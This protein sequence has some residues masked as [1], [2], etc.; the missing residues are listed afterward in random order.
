MSLYDFHS[1]VNK[2]NLSK[3]W[4]ERACK[5]FPG[6]ISHNIRFFPPYPFFVERAHGKNLQ[7]VDGNTFVDFWMGHWA[8]ILGHSPQN[9]VQPLEKALGQGTIFGTV[10]D[11][12]VLLGEIIQK[13]V[14]SAE[15]DEILFNW[16]RSN[17]VRYK[18][19]SRIYR[20]KNCCQST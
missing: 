9:V 4:Y 18:D 16:D 7:D 6:G 2:T 3:A 1:Y 8:L 19:C 11:T 12:S 14:P 10:N 20:K 17:Y 15:L 5:V 13:F